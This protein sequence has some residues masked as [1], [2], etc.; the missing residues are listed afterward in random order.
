MADKITSDGMKLR[1]QLQDSYR[2]ALIYLGLMQMLQLI[3]QY[4]N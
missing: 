1:I 4:W 3:L 2:G